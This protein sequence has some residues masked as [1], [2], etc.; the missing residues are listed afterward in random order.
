MKEDLIKYQDRESRRHLG[1]SSTLNG[2][3][4]CC[5]NKGETITVIRSTS[6]HIFGGYTS[7]SW[8]SSGKYVSDPNSFLFTLVNSNNIPPTKYPVQS[9]DE[10]VF[11]NSQ[12][13]IYH[14]SRFLQINIILMRSYGPT[15]GTGHD[16]QVDLSG[17][18][19]FAFPTTYLARYIS[20]NAV[21]SNCTLSEIEVFTTSK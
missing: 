12:G 4:S 16:M 7:K 10:N 20:D 6:G 11:D 5:D 15:F 14:H 9:D 17:N 8:T 13:H 2:F 1:R 21:F 19:S 3:H 18:I